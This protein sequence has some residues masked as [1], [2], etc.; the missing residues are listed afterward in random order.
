[1]PGVGY[2]A[3]F[4][5]HGGDSIAKSCAEKLLPAIVENVLSAEVSEQSL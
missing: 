1:L 2:F 5:G 4:D 3:V